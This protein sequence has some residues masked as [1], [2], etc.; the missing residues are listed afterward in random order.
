MSDE[1]GINIRRVNGVGLEVTGEFRVLRV[2]HGNHHLYW[3]PSY[4]AALRASGPFS[5]FFPDPAFEEQGALVVFS[6]HEGATEILSLT[7]P[8]GGREQLPYA[9][10]TR[11]EH[12]WTQFKL[13]ALRDD[14]PEEV[15]DFIKD[16]TPP[17]ISQFPEAYRIYKPRWYSRPR[18]LILWGLEPMGGAAFVKPDPQAALA[19]LRT[20]A[21]VRAPLLSSHPWI[22]A[23]IATAMLAVALLLLWLAQPRPNPGFE[24]QPSEGEAKVVKNLT[25]FEPGLGG[26]SFGHCDYDWAFSDGFPLFSSAES[27]VVTWK[28]AGTKKVT[29][30]ATN[31][32][33][34]GFLFK[35]A[36]IEKNV[37]VAVLP[38]K[39]SA[40][41]VPAPGTTRDIRLE[42]PDVL[43]VG[44]TGKSSLGGADTP[45]RPTIVVAKESGASGH[46]R[47]GQAV[48]MA[49][50]TGTDLVVRGESVSGK[51]GPAQPEPERIDQQSLVA[52]PTSSTRETGR[53]GSMTEAP[54]NPSWAGA[55]NGRNFAGTAANPG[56]TASAK[57]FPRLDSSSK[58]PTPR[59][60]DS[61]DA[62][63]G[64]PAKSPA[65]KGDGLEMANK[66]TSVDSNTSDNQGA[67]AAPL[68]GSKG[69]KNAV[70]A[71]A[72]TPDKR[73]PP[74]G[75][76]TPSAPLDGERSMA[77]RSEDRTRLEGEAPVK[78]AE[79]PGLP[80]G[81]I[82]T[83]L[84]G[85]VAETRPPQITFEVVRQELD[86]S[87]KDNHWIGM[88]FYAPRGVRIAKVYVDGELVSDRDTFERKLSVGA[89][90]IRVDYQAAAPDG[91]AAGSVEKSL[92]L[93]N[94]VKPK[95]ELS[96]KTTSPAQR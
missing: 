18:L 84:R 59:A 86:Q 34:L 63:T 16:F 96:D 56:N 42:Q 17:S 65:A 74:A 45:D 20:R 24:V 19:E 29:L 72:D 50:P 71:G 83:K 37:E 21:P 75:N 93:D 52:K 91:V 70:P 58:Q 2:S 66:P 54:V 80:L 87:D 88:R 73:L 81:P 10:W 85:G 49:T 94:L 15:R 61:E 53:S 47:D 68:A 25:T 26:L 60:A 38:Q 7:R 35:T 32:T 92:N 48:P 40:A 64:M 6:R 62:L 11:F 23:L 8:I 39:P 30:E 31:S 13:L 67:S 79:Q 27:P 89:H 78:G 82:G 46:A 22:A 33:L 44:V 76:R 3:Q 28:S 1:N 41:L 51:P 77:N 69:D 90:V 57:E 36:V 43:I 9:E 5:A 14:V 95:F 55:A 12:A 4:Q